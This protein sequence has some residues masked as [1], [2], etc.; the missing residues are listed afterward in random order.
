MPLSTSVPSHQH[1]TEGKN[2]SGTS[3][4][5]RFRSSAG[6]KIDTMAPFSQS[7]GP[8]SFW[9]L[10][11]AIKTQEENPV[12]VLPDQDEADAGK[13]TVVLDMDECLI[14]SVSPLRRHFR[15]GGTVE[16]RQTEKAAGCASLCQWAI[17]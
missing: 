12:Y 4:V 9:S 13:L 7:Q 16:P 5:S 3:K 1:D 10:S 6:L 2:D 8:K 17:Q 15:G 11:L 14:H